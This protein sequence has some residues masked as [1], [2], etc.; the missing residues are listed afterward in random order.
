MRSFVQRALVGLGMVAAGV[1]VGFVGRAW[2]ASMLPGTY[3]AMDF[4]RIEFGG[5]PPVP[6]SGSLSVA[7]LLGPREAPDARFRLVARQADV[8]L[9]SGHVVHALTFDGRSPGPELRVHQGDL[10]E[11]VLENDDVDGGVTIHWHGVDVPNAEDG[12]A[13]VTQDAVR[14]GE[15]YTYRF[16]ATRAGTYWYHSHQISDSEVRR[17]LFGAFVVL[18]REPLPPGTLDLIV[19]AHDFGGTL[20][21]GSSDRVE[22]RAVGPGTPV[23]LRLVNSLGRPLTFRVGPTPYRVLAIDGVDLNAPSPL[24]GT[25]LVLAGGGRYDIGFTMP[26][27]PAAL[28]LAG[29]DASLA[30]SPDGHAD[31]PPLEAETEFDPARYGRPAPTPFGPTARFDRTFTM[32]IGKKLGFMDGHVG[33]HWSLNGRVYPHVPMFVVER[34]D[35]VKVEIANKTSSVHP[36]HLHG[37]HALVLSRDGKPTTGSP[38]WVDTL[39]VDP[40]QRVEIAFRADNPGIWMD[41]CHNLRHA[42]AGL[43]MHVAYAGVSTPFALGG[44]SRNRPE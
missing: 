17:G 26:A 38:W 31:P 14:P 5:G 20:T 43:T 4:G 36:M 13:G 25:K 1:G 8:R 10:V 21:L 6:H 19:V 16:R 37:H 2:H 28:E 39:D 29:S 44:R 22:R 40:G 15:R 30:L 11:V 35:L 18:P 9:A 12:V 42:A 34:G 24:R 32:P 7:K 23:R 27:Q 3:N 41:H 33:F